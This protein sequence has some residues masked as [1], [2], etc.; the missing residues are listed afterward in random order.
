MQIA[1]NEDQRIENKMNKAAENMEHSIALTY[2]QNTGNKGYGFV[3]GM[4]Q[5][6]SGQ[7]QVGEYAFKGVTGNEHIIRNR[8]PFN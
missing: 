5:P 1:P 3:P 2:R 7:R 4:R 6:S 8:P